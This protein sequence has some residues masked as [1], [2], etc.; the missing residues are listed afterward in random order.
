[1]R[2]STLIY[3]LAS[4]AIIAIGLAQEQARCDR[5]AILQDVTSRQAQSGDDDLMRH[6][7]IVLQSY[8]EELKA[9]SA[10]SSNQALPDLSPEV[11]AALLL[12]SKAASTIA[13]AAAAG[14]S[15]FL[16]GSSQPN[17]STTVNGITLAINVT[18]VCASCLSPCISDMLNSTADGGNIN[19]IVCEQVKN[20]DYVGV[21]VTGVKKP[22]TYDALAIYLQDPSDSTVGLIRLI[23]YKWANQDPAYI[24]SGNTTF[25]HGGHP[26]MLPNSSGA[27]GATWPLCW[28][29]SWQG[30]L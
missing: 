4:Y 29:A 14:F 11:T 9:A 27:P 13:A 23:K 20:G 5:S 25:R 12:P 18:E 22:S 17:P 28:P 16:H 24:K 3:I 10:L 7:P 19:L 1:M 2:G 21:T 8:K 15:P 26:W 6:A 30:S